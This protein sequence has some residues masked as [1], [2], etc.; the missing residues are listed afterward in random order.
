M[1]ILKWTS[2]ADDDSS[3]EDGA[4]LFDRETASDSD[5]YEPD[6]KNSPLQRRAAVALRSLASFVA[7]KGDDDKTTDALR[8]LVAAPTDAKI[9]QAVV[10]RHQSLHDSKP[11]ESFAFKGQDRVRHAAA[12]ALQALSSHLRAN[13]SIMARCCSRCW[14]RWR[15]NRAI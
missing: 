7:L 6:Q 12:V 1:K 3:S 8:A 2:M 15:A 9:M 5:S 4:T 11:G 13:E 14:M 10:E